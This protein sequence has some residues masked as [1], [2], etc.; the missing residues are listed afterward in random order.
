MSKC[1]DGRVYFRNSG[2][3]GL[4][5]VEE[6]ITQYVLNIIQGSVVRSTFKMPTKMYTLKMAIKV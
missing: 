3:K 5:T 2:L 6:L 1:K 4:K